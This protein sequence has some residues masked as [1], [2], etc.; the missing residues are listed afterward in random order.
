MSR[1]ELIRKKRR[2]NTEN[3]YRRRQ[4]TKAAREARKKCSDAPVQK[5]RLHEAVKQSAIDRKE[6]ARMW[7]DGVP[8]SKMGKHFGISGP[9][10]KIT[11][12][13]FGLPERDAVIKETHGE[14]KCKDCVCYPCFQGI[15]NFDTNFALTCK[16][17][18]EKRQGV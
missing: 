7:N 9:Y 1:D 14:R 12:K 18:R 16:S 4:Q 6:F 2:E 3:E 13:K 15:E 10:V 17:Y 8:M 11:A 5:A